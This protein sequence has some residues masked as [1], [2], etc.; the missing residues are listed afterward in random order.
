MNKLKVCCN[1][2]SWHVKSATFHI[3]NRWQQAEKMKLKTIILTMGILSSLFGCR[4][5]K[6]VE[7][8]KIFPTEEFAIDQAKLEDGRPAIGSFNL[9]YKNYEYKFQYPCIPM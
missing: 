7:S 8:D 2:K 5:N 9:A 1:L 3:Q 6:K 4:Q